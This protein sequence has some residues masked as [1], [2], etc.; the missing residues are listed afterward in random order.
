MSLAIDM[1]KITQVLLPDGEWYE[2]SDASFELDSYEFVWE[3]HVILGGGNCDGVVSTGATW[4]RSLGSMDIRYVAPLT[5]I[6][7]V[8]L[9]ET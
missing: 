9:K 7:A 4:K 8:R 6:M 1:N 5:S 2:V 3:N